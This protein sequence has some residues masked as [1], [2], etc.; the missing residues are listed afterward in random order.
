MVG[1]QLDWDVKGPLQAGYRL[2]VLV[3]G[4]PAALP[5]GGV[6]VRGLSEVFDLLVDV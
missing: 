2:A 4:H 1:D 5:S 3:G 6:Q